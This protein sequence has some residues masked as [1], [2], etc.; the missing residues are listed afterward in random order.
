MVLAAALVGA[1][2]AAAGSAHRTLFR[3]PLASPDIL[4]VPAGTGPGA[5]LGIFLTLPVLG[6]QLLASLGG[7]ATVPPVYLVAASAHGREPVLVP[8]FAGIVVGALAG[9]RGRLRLRGRGSPADGPHRASRAVPAAGRLDRE[10]ATAA[11]EGLGIAD[12]AGTDGTRVSGGQRQLALV[13]RAPAQAAP[14]LLDAGRLAAPGP[15]DQVLEPG[16]L[17]EVHGVPV[18]LGRLADGRRPCPPDLR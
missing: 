5:V 6:L 10:A 1:A 12:L 14:T 13:T 8:A 3:N 2:P 18:L 17:A 11:L 9:T 16:R 15:A 4:G 7:L